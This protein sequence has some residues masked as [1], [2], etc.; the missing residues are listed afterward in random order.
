[1]LPKKCIA[2]IHR[3]LNV[4]PQAFDNVRKSRKS[5]H[6][7]IPGLLGHGIGERFVLQILVHVQPS[8]EQDDFK[9]VGGSGQHLSQQRV[10]IKR[11]RRYQRI[12]LVGR[13]LCRLGSGCRRGR[14][15]LLRGERQSVTWKEEKATKNC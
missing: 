11:D 15:S 5:L 12:Q 3:P 9:R 6:A 7:R 13:N 14:G 10:R 8:L 1:L 2:Q 4:I